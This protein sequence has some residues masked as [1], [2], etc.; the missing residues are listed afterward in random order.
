MKNT[1]FRMSAL[2]IAVILIFTGLVS[3]TGRQGA[4]TDGRT[5]VGGGRDLPENKPEDKPTGGDPDDNPDGKPADGVIGSRVEGEVPPS[6]DKSGSIEIRDGDYDAEILPAPG[7]D[8]EYIGEIPGDIS[9]GTGTIKPAPGLLTCGEWKDADHFEF[10]SK[11]F[12]EREE[13]LEAAKR[14]SIVPYNMI[15]VSVLDKEAPCF[16]VKATLNGANGAVYNAVTDIEGNAYLFYNIRDE[17]DKPESV[18]VAGKDYQLDGKTEITIDAG[19]A[20]I[21]V[22]ELDLMLMIDTT[23][24]MSDELE[25]IKT[26]LA[27]MVTRISSADEALSIRVSVNFYRDEGDEYIVK[28]YGFRTDINECLAQ[29]KSQRADGGG[30]FPEAVH[31]ALENAVSGHEWREDA[32]KICFL[33]LDA[34]PHSESERQGVNSSLLNSVKTAAQQGIRIIPV[35]SSGVDT[36]TEI[37]L[38]SFAIMTGGTYIFLTDHSGIG[39]PHLEATVG[40]YTVEQLND[41]MVR[42]VC[43]YCGIS[44]PSSAGEVSR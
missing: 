34:P 25:Y 24:S 37:I 22:T 20:G 40:Q 7:I 28:Y 1:F 29:I 43:E 6:Y 3:C 38:R 5:L 32:V 9:S 35:A 19:E 10:F 26:E 12:E 27:D 11:L 17:E 13:W 21:K 33:V 39:G 4:V 23:G 8:G 18:T 41:C 42:V 15:K 2:L 16:G 31:T 44:A 30:D 36:A 14:R